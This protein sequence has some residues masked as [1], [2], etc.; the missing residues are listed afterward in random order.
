MVFASSLLSRSILRTAWVLAFCLGLGFQQSADAA[1]VQARYERNPVPVG[2]AATLVVEVQDG[3]PSAPPRVQP[4]PGIT[5]GYVGES[6][7]ITFAGGRNS[8]VFSYRYQVLA[9]GPGEYQLPPVTLTVDN[10]PQTVRPPL[11]T[12]TPSNLPSQDAANQPAF[13][14]LNVAKTN[15]YIGEIIPMSVEIFF[16]NARDIN[17]PNLPLEGCTLGVELDHQQDRVRVG[18]RV[19]NRIEFPKT[20][21][22]E[23][24]GTLTLGP[25]TTSLTVLIPTGRSNPFDLFG[26][27]EMEARPMNLESPPIPLQV[28]PLPSEGRPKDF[29]GAVGKFSEFSVEASPTQ[30]KAGDPVTLKVRI[31]GEG[32]L[33]A[34]QLPRMTQ[35][36]GFQSYPPSSKVEYNDPLHTRGTRSIEQ[37]LIPESDGEVQLPPLDFHFFNPV[38]ERYESIPG[39]KLTLQVEP[40]TQSPAQPTVT[41]GNTTPKQE[42]APEDQPRST[43]VHIKP[44]PG[45]LMT[46]WNPWI[47][48]GSFWFIW[49]TPL[50][51]GFWLRHWLQKRASRL[52]DVDYQ[53]KI[54]ADLREAEALRQL[55]RALQES[56]SLECH[57]RILEAL[58]SRIG[59]RLHHPPQGIT[60]EIV[61]SALLP[62]GMDPELASSIQALMSAAEQAR[63]APALSEADLQQSSN[64]LRKCLEQLKSWKPTKG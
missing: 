17:R 18:Q 31:S 49:A 57:A 32:R 54:A 48:R 42:A 6:T 51:L 61:S 1:T 52:A 38:T 29:S 27:Q 39:P 30:L 28:L 33:E 12:V 40:S 5:L 15:A 8:M 22:P 50:V 47:T 21:I 25:V 59:E 10:Q 36:D 60:S 9:N 24:A 56:D 55:D 41:L 53:R 23:K 20:L 62:Q 13:L 63:Y 26:R 43:L 16:T 11:L 46:S 44:R 34:I 58:Q 3:R 19:F 7:Q 37:V 64:H 2:Q 45:V 14:Q 4:I 35:W